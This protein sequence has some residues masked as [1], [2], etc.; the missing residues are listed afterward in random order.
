LTIAFGVHA[1]RGE[2]QTE[3]QRCVR[4]YAETVASSASVS[5][6]LASAINAEPG[7]CGAADGLAFTNAASA[8]RRSA[9]SARA[10][11]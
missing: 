7:M 8:P 5:L 10:C 6:R 1:E 2:Q 3:Q 11:R 9:S 4:Q